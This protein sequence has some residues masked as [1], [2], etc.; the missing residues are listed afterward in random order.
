MLYFSADE[1]IDQQAEATDQPNVS[2]QQAQ[3][4]EVRS[5]RTYKQQVL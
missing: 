3:S 4:P 5:K 2:Q 1:N